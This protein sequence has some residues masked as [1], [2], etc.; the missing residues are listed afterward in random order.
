VAGRYS[1]EHELGRGGM[2][3]VF[4]A[5]DVALER[6]VAI[7][8]LPPALAVS[9]ELRDRFLREA[10]TAAGLSHP[11]IVPIHA[12]EDRDDLV[13]FVMGYVEGE[14][15]GQLVRRT[16]PLP[17]REVVRIVQEVA[18]ALGYAHGRG[19][20]HRD[21]KPDNILLE[22]VTDRA[23]V[24]DFGI[25]R[26]LD[27]PG[28]TVPGEIVGTMHFL[29][30]EQASGEPVDGRTDLWALGVTA[31]YALTGL[32]PF[33][34]PTLPATLARIMTAPTPPVA[35]RRPDLPPPVAETIDR[36]LAKRPAE[37]FPTGEAV[38][39]ALR[40]AFRGRPPQPP[41]VRHFLRSVQAAE[42]GGAALFLT[43]YVGPELISAL[44]PDRAVILLA[45]G[46]VVVGQSIGS[47]GVALANA[48][49]LYRL[50]YDWD[51]VR[52]FI[53]DAR[54]EREE[55]AAAV[56]RGETTP[57]RPLLSRLGLV[58]F[59]AGS[60]AAVVGALALSQQLGWSGWPVGLGVG[61][62]VAAAGTVAVA[63][64]R[65]GRVEPRKPTGPPLLTGTVGRWLYRL[66]GLGRRD[67]TPA[68][69]AP[70]RL[71]HT[72]LRLV[73][74]ID[75][76]HAAL[77]PGVREALAGA[78]RLAARLEQDI[79]RIRERLAALADAAARAGGPEAAARLAAERER[80]RIR[81]ATAVTAL[82]GL[83]LDLL[84]VA[85]GVATPDD[86]TANLE[87]ARAIHEA[88]DAQLIG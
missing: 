46:L 79:S 70:S 20:I 67:V 33:D 54:A 85:A 23:L 56:R 2:G 15:L 75:E 22:R 42:I 77:P 74:A 12:V 58:V 1:L 24:T 9:P 41:E 86:L 18:W 76:A 28:G 48:R 11:H 47:I 14:S 26:V 60:V 8:L 4:L 65:F 38:A 17:V 68:T 51:D 40:E 55:D 59:G 87:R 63:V 73:N 3:I 29:S 21:V 6:P 30:P 61:V 32:L 16:G 34:A 64:S 37:R 84:R 80:L 57:T 88:V 49:R 53:L 7:K 31:Y 36:L 83:R 52:G 39:E 82:E 27:R 69:P 72:E 19:V 13:Y 78:P 45:T 71:A 66:A 10:R 44:W 81:L 62:A 5:H 25:A 35:A 43:V 50:G